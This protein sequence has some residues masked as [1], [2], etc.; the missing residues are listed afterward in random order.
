M[1]G[2]TQI[3]EVNALYIKVKYYCLTC[4]IFL[5]FI[6]LRG[7]SVRFFAYA[8]GNRK[9]S[10]HNLMEY[11]SLKKIQQKRMSHTGN[12]NDTN[13]IKL[14]CQHFSWPG[15][16]VSFEIRNSVACYSE[17]P[18]KGK[19]I[20]PRYVTAYW[21]YL[22]TKVIFSVS[23]KM[24]LQQFTLKRLYGPMPPR[25]PLPSQNSLHAC[26]LSTLF[27]LISRLPHHNP[28]RKSQYRHSGIHIL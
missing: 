6:I 16:L 15:F 19:T 17:I 1:D 22:E 11:F 25:S 21:I 9:C 7:C 27:L 20:L 24:Q 28:D 12:A 26:L 8:L 18:V 14:H 13:K 23:P 10:F 4:F 5:F 2:M 3:F